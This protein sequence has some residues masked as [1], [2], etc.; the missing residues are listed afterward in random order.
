MK[1]IVASVGLFAVGASGVH[2]ASIM[3]PTVEGAKPWSIAA[4]LRGFYD[5]NINTAPNG[6]FKKSS[7]GF[8]VSPS[9][10]LNWTAEQTTMSLN[11]VYDFRYYD[12]KPNGNADHYD[13]THTFNALLNHSFSE[14]YVLNVSDSFVIG[15]EPDFLRTGPTLTDFQRIPGDNI[16]NYGQI[17]FNAQLTRL[18]G[19]ELGYQNSFFKYA[20]NAPTS[21]D[22]DTGALIVSRSALLDRIE[23]YVHIDGRWTVQPETTAVVG[24]RYGQTDYTGDK[25][26]GIDDVLV[27]ENTLEPV[28][29]LSD[30]R[31]QRSH[32][33][34]V[35]VDHVFRPD[36][37]ASVRVG[38]LYTDHYNEPGGDRTDIGPSAQASL[39]Y[40]YLP[41][42]YLELG[43]T[44]DRNATD[45]FSATGGNLTSDAESTTVFGTINHR[46]MPRLYGSVTGQ[47]QNSQLSGGGFNNDNERY[48]LVGLNVEYRFNPHLSAHA[49]YNYDKLDSD[50]GGRSFD[51]NRVYIGVTAS[52]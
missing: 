27:D 43:L 14:R 10:G 7:F 17:K 51:R 29:Y 44:H 23:H 48:Y 37:K 45:L 5:D 36:L 42:S 21:I 25:I 38:A 52:Y 50:L 28:A 33:G 18:F 24:Y 32:Y 4:T 19:L 34:Y 3:A 35:G 39:Q 15:Q 47:F 16:R 40:T 11:Y 2:A 12:R 9:L 13:Q 46:I 31:N 1:N 41:E 30:A 20:D 6:D 26:I 8:E 49:G 22:P